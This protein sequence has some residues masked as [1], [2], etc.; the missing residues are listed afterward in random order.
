MFELIVGLAAF[1]YIADMLLPAAPNG[2]SEGTRAS[3]D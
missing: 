2:E 1:I 3:A